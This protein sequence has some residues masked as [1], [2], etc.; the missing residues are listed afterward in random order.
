MMH[1]GST[2]TWYT[3]SAGP[4]SAY[5]VGSDSPVK[6]ASCMDSTKRLPYRARRSACVC[7]ALG[8]SLKSNEA[9]DSS[10]VFPTPATVH[11]FSI[12]PQSFNTS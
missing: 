6:L 3:L 8:Y 12:N 5:D 2:R 9:E 11:S 4:Y 1:V 7:A 10:A